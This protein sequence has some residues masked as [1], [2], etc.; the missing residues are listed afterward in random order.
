M[1]ISSK[2]IDMCKKAHEIQDLWRPRN[3]DFFYEQ[4][5]KN[6]PEFCVAVW[7]HDSTWCADTKNKTWLPRQDQL[8]TIAG[9]DEDEGIVGKWIE[10]GFVKW[11]EDK[12][13]RTYRSMI[14]AGFS[15]M[16]QMWLGYVMTKW[17]NK[18][19]NETELEAI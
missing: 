19:F 2:Y 14:A 8:Q 7:I 6:S 16:E 9:V 5:G 17:F 12:S 4:S 11:T 3:G 18:R 1:D 10:W 13:K 15:S